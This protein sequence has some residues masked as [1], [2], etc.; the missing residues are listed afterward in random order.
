MCLYFFSEMGIKELEKHVT[1]TISFEENYCIKY[2][3]TVYMTWDGLFA[4]LGGVFGL[5]LGGSFISLVDIV[6]FMMTRSLGAFVL[7]RL[8]CKKRITRNPKVFIVPTNYQF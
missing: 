6:Y 3:R 1:V 4:A 5:C 8:S 2:R 7:Q